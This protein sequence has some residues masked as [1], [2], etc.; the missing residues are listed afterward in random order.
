MLATVTTDSLTRVWDIATG[1]QIGEA[2]PPSAGVY[3]VAF[4]PHAKRLA[5]ADGDGNVIFWDIDTGRQYG[6]PISVPGG[7]REILFTPDGANLFTG[8]NSGA[9]LRWRLPVPPASEEE[10][11]Q[12]TWATTGLRAGADDRVER[13]P[14]AEWRALQPATAAP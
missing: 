11:E 2:L 10:M 13:I 3:D 6:T 12:R 7:V 4:H 1:E 14:R 5:T 9:A 8:G